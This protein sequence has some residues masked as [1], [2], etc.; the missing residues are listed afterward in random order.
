[1]VIL[2]GQMMSV[3]F[4]MFLKPLGH[5][6]VDLWQ[7]TPGRMCSRPVGDLADL[8]A[9]STGV[10]SCFQYDVNA[11]IYYILT[12]S[13]TGTAPYKQVCI[14]MHFVLSMFV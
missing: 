3:Q 14:L 8:F 1:M 11:A 4:I 5:F 10:F 7:C 2:D 9:I 13:W 6:Q 12:R